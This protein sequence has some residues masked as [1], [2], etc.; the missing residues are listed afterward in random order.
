MLMTGIVSM[1]RFRSALRLA[2][3]LQDHAAKSKGVCE[4]PSADRKACINSAAAALTVPGTGAQMLGGVQGATHVAAHSSAGSLLH[5]CTA[6]R[7]QLAL[8]AARLSEQALIVSMYLSVRDRLHLPPG[9]LSALACASRAPA[10]PMAWCHPVHP[11]QPTLQSRNSGEHFQ[12][13]RDG[14]CAQLTGASCAHT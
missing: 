10:W 11:L 3:H 13:T 1:Y 7:Q 9:T 2:A 14:T 6:V 4:Q 8:L 5:Q 12:Q